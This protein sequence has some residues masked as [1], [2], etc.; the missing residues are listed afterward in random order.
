MNPRLFGYP[1]LFRERVCGTHGFLLCWR[2]AGE[3][4]LVSVTKLSFL[5][6]VLCLTSLEFP[7]GWEIPTESVLNC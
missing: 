2:G 3:S 6:G 7:D 1:L 4:G 5:A